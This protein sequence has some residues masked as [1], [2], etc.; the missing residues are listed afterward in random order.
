MQVRKRRCETAEKGPQKRPR[1][2]VEISVLQER[3]QIHVCNRKHNDGNELLIAVATGEF[4]KMSMRQT[5]EIR[6]LLGEGAQDLLVLLSDI[7]RQPENPQSV[8]ANLPS[9]KFFLSI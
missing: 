8:Y 4:D 3:L 1:G 7:L 6:Q 9:E 2:V 5:F